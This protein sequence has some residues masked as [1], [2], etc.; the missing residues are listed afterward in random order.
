MDKNAV[1]L[2]KAAK[3]EFIQFA[4][5]AEHLNQA[6]NVAVRNMIYTM[7]LKHLNFDYSCLGETFL[8]LVRSYKQKARNGEITLEAHLNDE[9]PSTPL[10]VHFTTNSEA[11]A[12]N[13]FNP[14]SNDPPAPI[15]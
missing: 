7:F 15:T 1:S 5:F 13:S 9:I 14:S 11:I 8:D 12:V 6:I 2:K 10:D 4:E 3:D